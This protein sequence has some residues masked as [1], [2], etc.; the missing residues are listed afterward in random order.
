MF[1]VVIRLAL[2]S[3]LERQTQQIISLTSCFQMVDST[4]TGAFTDL[5][6]C[7]NVSRRVLVEMAS[8]CLLEARAVPQDIQYAHPGA[9]LFTV[10]YPTQYFSIFSKMWNP[11]PVSGGG[12][13]A[14]GSRCPCFSVHPG[15]CVHS[16]GVRGLPSLQNETLVFKH[17]YF[18]SFKIGKSLDSGRLAAICSY[19]VYSLV[20]LSLM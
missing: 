4:C 7:I 5:K 15:H 13:C 1:W 12:H 16:G 14:V 18:G 10:K 6:A 11:A 3:K 17:D 9:S 2:L 20:L 19:F 8:L